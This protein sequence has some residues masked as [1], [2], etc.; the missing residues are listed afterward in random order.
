MSKLVTLNS[1]KELLDGEQTES[2][3]RL[4]SEIDEISEEEYLKVVAVDH[5]DYPVIARVENFDTKKKNS[6]I[7]FQINL[8]NIDELNKAQENELNKEFLT[9]NSIM[10][11]SSV[12]IANGVYI[13]FGELSA[14]SSEE[15]IL[16]EIDTLLNNLM[17]ILDDLLERVENLGDYQSA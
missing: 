2:G 1:L 11:L 13:L 9:V 7:I 17:N 4:T 15:D 16:I 12:S 14:T 3:Y 8:F 10:D 5:E 6:R